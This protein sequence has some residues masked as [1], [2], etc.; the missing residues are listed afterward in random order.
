MKIMAYLVIW[1]YLY[2]KLSKL[3]AVSRWYKFQ[4]TL[5]LPVIYFYRYQNI[6][7]SKKSFRQHSREKFLLF[8][9]YVFFGIWFE[10]CIR[11]LNK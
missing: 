10:N 11:I 8:V 3:L 1:Q 6:N 7:S 4:A 9:Q 2:L 5:Y